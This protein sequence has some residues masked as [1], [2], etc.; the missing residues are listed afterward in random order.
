MTYKEK[1]SLIE[2]I[3]SECGKE[4]KAL[5]LGYRQKI[6]KIFDRVRDRKIKELKKNILL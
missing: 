6:L 4:I 3:E 5:T 2:K 1:V